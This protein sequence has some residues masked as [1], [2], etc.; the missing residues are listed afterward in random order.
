[1]TEQHDPFDATLRDRIGAAES[2][3]RVSPAPLGGVPAAPGPARWLRPALVLATAAVA[4][5]LAVLVIGQ[6]PDRTIGGA[7]PSPSAGEGVSASTRNGDFVLTLSSPRSTWTTE[8][9]IEIT[10]MLS[11]DGDRPQVEISG[12]AGPVVFTLVQLEGGDA[13]LLEGAQ[14]LPCLHVSL[15]PD[16]PLV[17]PYQKTGV[18]DSYPPFDRAFFDDPELHLPPGRW[19]IR[20]V[21]D[22]GD[23]GCENIRRLEVSIT[24][25]I[26]EAEGSPGPS[27]VATEPP[28]SSIPAVPAS[29][30]PS[31]TLEA[32]PASVTGILEGDPQLE[33]GCVWL[34]DQADTAWEVI[35]PEPYEA[36]F[37]E[38][39]AVL[40]A[41]GGVVARAGDRITVYGSRPAGAGS[42]CMVGI[43]YEAE[44]VLIR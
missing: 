7:T 35:W 22:F 38:G 24:L 10:A 26:L 31:A 14:H 30:T 44:S 2:R 1:M 16:S 17:W 37:R 21:L 5:V 9:A 28:V 13:A 34:R 12:G 3:V 43:V 15:G 18:V 27:A 36:T 25:A 33:G 23:P 40:V 4:V 29:P 42:H 39:S 20:A 8:D 6:L 19:E 41:D 32:T 11:Y